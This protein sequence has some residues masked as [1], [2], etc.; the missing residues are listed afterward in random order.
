MSASSELKS[1]A[2]HV[3]F[4]ALHDANM[5]YTNQIEKVK[6]ENPLSTIVINM[7]NDLRGMKEGAAEKLLSAAEKEI[8]RGDRITF[9]IDFNLGFTGQDVLVSD[10]I[11]QYMKDR[12]PEINFECVL[13]GTGAEKNSATDE[14][15]LTDTKEEKS[16]SATITVPS[17]DL[18]YVLTK[19]D[20]GNAKQRTECKFIMDWMREQNL[21]KIKRDRSQS[22]DAGKQKKS[23]ATKTTTSEGASI[24]KSSSHESLSHVKD[25]TENKD[26]KAL[27]S[28]GETPGDAQSPFVPKRSVG[29]SS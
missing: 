27:D 20:I 9:V 7:G 18:K 29:K 8:K 19:G 21:K 25:A 11:R 26:E 6:N 15:K 17:T 2:R 14:K 4:V 10:A 28:I 13:V 24:R 3:I 5:M 12:H 16:F 23:S 1:R 22:F